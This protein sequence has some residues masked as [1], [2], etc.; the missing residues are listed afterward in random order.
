MCL[1]DHMVYS[2]KSDSVWCLPCALFVP[3]PIRDTLGQFVNYGC[4][5][6]A[7]LNAEI[8]DHNAKKYHQDAK[9]MAE[10]VRRRFEKPTKTLPYTINEEKKEC[11][12][13]YKH[14]LK[15][16]AKSVH[17][18]GKQSI[19]FRGHLEDIATG[20]PNNNPGNFLTLLK[21]QKMTAQ[22]HVLTKKMFIQL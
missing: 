4:S 9:L 13:K 2:K 5:K 12:L 22:L 6:W 14:I 11:L 15:V 8:K 10:G 7:K 17:Y 20:D 16:I 1:D 19:A 18:L 3:E 21:L